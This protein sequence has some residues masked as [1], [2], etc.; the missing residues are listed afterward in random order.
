MI[1]KQLYNEHGEKMSPI[2]NS[3]S[4]IMGGVAL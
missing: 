4:V 1:N 3:D 2:V